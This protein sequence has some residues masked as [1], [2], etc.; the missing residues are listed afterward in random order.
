MRIVRRALGA[1]LAA[2]ALAG[3]VSYNPLELIGLGSA[4][5]H[6]PTPLAPFTSQVTPRAV[7]TASVGKSGGFS[8]RPDVEGGRIYTASSDGVITILDED[9]G[10]VFSRS[11]T[12]KQI[13]GGVEVGESRIV[14]GTLK[15][16][17]VALDA[18]GKQVWVTS[19]AG[20]V[21]A[22]PSVSRK[23]AVVRTSDGRIF[24]LSIEDGR[25]LWV[26]QRPAPSLLLRSDAGV[27]AIGADVLAGYP[28]G[29]L[30]ALDIEDGKLTWEVTVTQPR[31]ATELERIA[32]V[33]GLPLIDGNN[34][35]AAAFQGKVACFEIQSRNLLWARDVSSARALAR[36]AKYVYVVDDASAVHALDKATGASVWKQD[37]LAWRKLT[38]PM[39]LDGRIVVGDSLGFLHVLAPEDGAI[40]GR[41]ATDGSAINSMIPAAGGLALQTAKGSVSL[42][43]F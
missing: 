28:N 31:G 15:G 22:P 27:L 34:V 5:A 39:V 26:F 41:L 42:V 25:R 40:I 7:W 11:E 24:G 43:R 33:A 4:P 12:K 20:E 23:V 6:K 17:V 36:D 3:C 2:T 19:V 14:V 9:T 37:K 21:I 13:S 30:I 35:C 16:E 1:A 32:D 8:F 38:A 10:K 18:A 29:K